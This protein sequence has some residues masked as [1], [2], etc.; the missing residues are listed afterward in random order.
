MNQTTKN[1]H[2]TG[3]LCG[4]CLAALAARAD[5]VTLYTDARVDVLAP[6]PLGDPLGPASSGTLES[7]VDQTSSGQRVGMASALA[8]DKGNVEVG[9]E[10][11]MG[12]RGVASAM[13]LFTTRIHNPETEFME[14]LI[15]FTVLPGELLF[16]GT[17][18]FDLPTI[19]GRYSG[20]VGYATSVTSG[21]GE[22]S[23]FPECK[24]GIDTESKAWAY[25]A[26]T[27]PCGRSLVERIYL[28]E[29]DLWGFS[30][31]QQEV[32]MLVGMQPG[33]TISVA[34]SLFARAESRFLDWPGLFSVKLGDPLDSTVGSGFS[35]T[36]QPVDHSVPAPASGALAALALLT[37]AMNRRGPRPGGPTVPSTAA[38]PSRRASAAGS[39]AAHR[40]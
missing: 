13:S 16:K 11:A 26:D 29:S 9:V 30:T 19:P 20:Q 34:Y 8:D 25:A 17:G 18:D 27:T 28:G 31:K 32:Y 38:A 2:A 3:L 6:G 37:L 24:V 22:T 35:V 14:A 7:F 5:T 40:A 10:L 15:H 21:K 36:F 33:E 39:G 12:W 4:L 23:T 1:L